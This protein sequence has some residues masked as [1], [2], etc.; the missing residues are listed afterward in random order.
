[1]FDR[2]KIALGSVG[3]ETVHKFSFV[4]SNIG[5][6][7]GEFNLSCTEECVSIIQKSGELE[8]GQ[9]LTISISLIG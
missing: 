2:P 7:A 4:L 5:I 3:A 6:D 1:M 8:S 9:S